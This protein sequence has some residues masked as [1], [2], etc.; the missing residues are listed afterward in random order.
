[1]SLSMDDAVA[2]IRHCVDL[3][4]AFFDT[5][6]R[7]ATS[8]EKL[9]SALKP[10]RDQVIIATKTTERNAAGAAEHI[11]ASLR[12]LQTDR[13]DLYQLH[14]LSNRDALAQALAPQGAYEAVLKA[15]ATGKIRCIGFSSHS[16]GVAL[17]A[18]KTGLFQTLQFPFNFIESDP[19]EELFPEASRRGMG[20]IAMKPLGG[21]RLERADLCFKFLQQHP[22]IL[23]IPGVRE[24][25]EVDQI[26]ALYRNPE[27]LSA[28][29]LEEI[30]RIRSDLGAKFCH[31]CEYCLPCEQG[32]EIPRVLMLQVGQAKVVTPGCRGFNRDLQWKRWTGASIAPSASRNAPTTF[33]FAA[34]SRRTSR[35]ISIIYC[36]DS[37]QESAES[38][39]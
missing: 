14:N 1:M 30:E 34:C 2:V 39:Y 20:I 13:I 35:C 6:N 32:V 24:T 25:G 21:G 10:F 31:R 11:D 9:G 12:R 3:G 28:R 7:Y 26:A 19:L 27:P 4:I 23:P 18:V 29:D 37:P 33:R 5:A 36:L 8:E 22:H 38:A 15:Q 16:I 17:E